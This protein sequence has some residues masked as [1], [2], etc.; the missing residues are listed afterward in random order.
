MKKIIFALVVL[1]AFLAACRK[2]AQ[3]KSVMYFIRGLDSTY[4][5]WYLNEEGKTIKQ[6]VKPVGSKFLW[7]YN[8]KGKPGDMM[9]LYIEYDKDEA[10]KPM[11]SNFRVMIKVDDVIFKD[12]I[13]Q[14]YI[15]N[16]T[17]AVVK[18]SGIIPF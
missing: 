5:V 8:W 15:K 4:T 2:D 11:G 6:Q 10:N 17:V 1:V 9:Y 3:E 14:D 16:N 12:A 13:N 18:R 7:T